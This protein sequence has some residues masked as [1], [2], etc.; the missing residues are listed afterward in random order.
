MNL[1]ETNSYWAKREEE[2]NR[3]K[4]RDDKKLTKA[5]EERQRKAM[6]EIQEQIDAFY[7]RYADKEGI[8][9]S[10]ARKRVETIDMKRYEGKAKRYVKGAH[11]GVESIAAQSFTKQANEEMRLYNLT[12]KVNRLELLKMNIDLELIAMTNDVESFLYKSFNRYVIDE[13]ERL[14]GILGETLNFNER[15]V[16]SIVQSSFMNATW[17][18]RLWGDNTA[19]RN[20]LDTLLHRGIIQGRNPRELARDVKKKFNTS[21]YESERLLRSELARVQIQVQE[22]SYKQA[23]ITKY[24]IVTESTACEIC[25]PFDGKVYDLSEMQIGVNSPLFHANCRCSTSAYYDRKAWEKRMK[26]KGL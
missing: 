14:S 26:G 19:L 25:K 1:E 2:N 4:I 12:M 16:K 10:E 15:H 18:E 13:Y 23:G 11:S 8:S 7:G 5:I 6:N 17:S 24:S 20:E 22:D 21:T 9:I 3:K